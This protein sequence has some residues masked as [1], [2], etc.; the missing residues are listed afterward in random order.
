MVFRSPH[1]GRYVAVLGVM[2][3]SFLPAGLD[4]RHLAEAAEG[5]QIAKE[6]GK[7]TW[8]LSST[9]WG[10]ANL[11]SA[12]VD[13]AE[14]NLAIPRNFEMVA[15]IADAKLADGTRATNL[16]TRS[17]TGAKIVTPVDQSG[18]VRVEIGG[19]GAVTL[20]AAAEQRLVDPA[21]CPAATLPI[22]LS[23]VH[24][25]IRRTAPDRIV[26]SEA[27]PAVLTDVDIEFVASA[28]DDD[29]VRAED[30]V[31][32]LTRRYAEA[33]PRIHVVDSGTNGGSVSPFMRR[34]RIDTAA[35]EQLTIQGGILPT[36]GILGT[37]PAA[38][39][40]LFSQRLDAVSAASVDA[41]FLNLTPSATE[42][43]AIK[44][45]SLLGT[46]TPS[47]PRTGM[48][49]VTFPVDLGVAGQLS[50]SATVRLVGR[51]SST[52]A[53][54]SIATVELRQNGLPLISSPVKADGTF[55]LKA[56]SGR[57]ATSTLEIVASLPPH[58]TSCSVATGHL[59]VEILPSSEI[60]FAPGHPEQDFAQFVATVAAGS[61]GVSF[62]QSDRGTRELGLRLVQQVQIAGVAPLRL[63]PAAAHPTANVMVG[64]TDVEFDEMVPW[65]PASLIGPNAA[66][67]AA[68]TSAAPLLVVRGDQAA[69]AALVDA[70]AIGQ[71]LG[72]LDG[73]L[74]VHPGIGSPLS[75]VHAR[76]L[77]V[78]D[79]SSS[80]TGPDGTAAGL[81]RGSTS[82]PSV[83]GSANVASTASAG[84]PKT[85]ILIASGALLVLFVWLLRFVGT[86]FQRSRLK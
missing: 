21:T 64:L 86:R 83:S 40:T 14:M 31:A 47:R 42:P 48:G 24:A 27:L 8:S 43:A 15:L 20:T 51:L 63:V 19:V 30:L 66:L 6:L 52:D 54:I 62:G 50:Q 29:L 84:V 73:D 18:P 49:A 38:L 28:T 17:A 22:E 39:D 56:V 7:G 78:P 41:S 80:T 34:F 4:G 76:P 61:F 68:G 2:V 23:N 36:I 9:A 1:A 46:T 79:S 53:D 82:Q 60:S 75:V 67:A 70:L 45:D 58:R 71:R 77:L 32:R 44:T 13:P 3:W 25:E 59:T 33:V 12:G 57:V 11:I 72:A 55:E 65:F 85:V 74:A 26:L 37:S 35:P 81:S 10:V 69:T 16:V 5:G